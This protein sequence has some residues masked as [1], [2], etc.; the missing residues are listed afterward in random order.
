MVD[1][2]V[3]RALGWQPGDILSWRVSGGL[4]VITRPGYGR[5]RG[6]TK[7]GHLSLPAAQRRAVGI[8]IHDRILL[9]A[10]PDQGLLVVYPQQTLDEMAARRFAEGGE[11]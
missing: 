8:R 10:D 5:R 1:K 7:Y 6:V 4:I 3:L 9:A 11:P 2:S